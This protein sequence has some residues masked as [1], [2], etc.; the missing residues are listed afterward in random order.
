MPRYDDVADLSL[1]VESTDRVQ[2]RSETTSD[3]E[4]VTTEVRL[5]GDGETGRGEDVTYDVEDH[6]ILASAPAFDDPDGPF[7]LTGEYTF[8]AFSRALDG[9]DLFPE[10]P[11]RA[12]ARS[13][14]RWALE[15]AALDLALRQNDTDL[16][17]AVGREP[18]PV[19]F[20]VSTRLGDPPSTA[21]VDALLDRDP[22]LEFKLDSTP[23][24]D[25]ALVDALAE[26][27]AVRLLD[28]KGWYENTD[29]DVEADPDLYEL[30][31][32]RFPDAIV[33]DPAPD[34][35]VRALLES[36]ADRLSFDYPVSNVADVVRLPFE[37]RWLNVKPSR[38]GTVQSLFE[39]IS[40]CER[41]GIRT[42][43]GGQFEL[44]VGRDQIQ[45]L[46]ALWYPDAPNDVAP[47][48]FNVP[49]Y[50]GDLPSSP[51]VLPDLRG[52]GWAE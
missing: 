15:S 10:P 12:G 3:F 28:L 37:P 23:D 34:P 30:V 36:H 39:T 50:D 16:G 35:E 7:D 32:E 4:R 44:S 11:I 9:V 45:T 43:G 18:D 22:T 41:R 5:H 20:V 24:W 17:S 47:S 1:V 19:R 6:E 8:D 38:F 48:A 26:T 33:E 25:R 27:D 13:Y 14:R 40:Y 52:F 46:A 29:V 42:Y 31:L 2:H 51:L 21:R 49:D